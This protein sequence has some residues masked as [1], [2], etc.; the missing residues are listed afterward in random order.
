MLE[1]DGHPLSNS[2]LNLA[3]A[4]FGVIGMLDDLSRLKKGL[5][6]SGH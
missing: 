4:P 5:K 6:G 3:P 1:I 2:R